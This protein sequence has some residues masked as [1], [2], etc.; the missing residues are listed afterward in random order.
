MD[1][2]AFQSNFTPW[3]WVIV[4]T[5][6]LATVAIGVYAKR[7]VV[8]MTDFLLAGR[9]LRPE[10][11]VVTMVATELGLVSVMYSAQQGF[12]HGF[13]AFHVGLAAGAG[14]LLVG[15]TGFV[16]VPLRR[17]GVM[18]IPE[19]YQRRFG[20]GVRVVAGGVLSLAGIL[21]MG[22]FL[23]VGVL[24]LMGI[25]GVRDPLALKLVMTVVLAG[26][27]FPHLQDDILPFPADLEPVG[28]LV[29]YAGARREP[30][31]VQ[32]GGV[33]ELP[34]VGALGSG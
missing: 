12:G 10:L 22:L 18:T 26:I 5:I 34:Q 24:F 16:V 8:N 7:R 25:T 11:G 28:D 17:M 14:M 13:S 21:K 3:D 9:T 20:R 30:H 33:N 27:V 6:L 4:A 29:R 1:L 15:L 32:F 19:F 23:Q 2:P 31:G